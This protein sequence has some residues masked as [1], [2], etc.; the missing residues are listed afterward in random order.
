MY[1]IYVLQ[2]KKDNN[3]YVGFTKDIAL[4]FEEHCS[5]KVDSTKNR[6][7]LKIIYFEGC[8][9]REDALKREK[10]LKTFYGNMFLHNRLKS[11]FNKVKL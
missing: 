6:R 5:G 3:N 11:Y 7:P 9:S 8:I 2:S 1:Y 10:Y 4:R